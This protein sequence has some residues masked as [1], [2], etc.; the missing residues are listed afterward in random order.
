MP[1]EYPVIGLL[2]PDKLLSIALFADLS[3]SSRVIDFGCGFGESLMHLANQFHITGMGI[4]ILANH[5]D[6]ANAALE[7]HSEDIEFVQAD[8][9][10]YPFVPE[11]FDMAICI[12]ATNMFGTP[13]IMFRNAI[14]FMRRAIKKTGHLLIAEPCYN[15][16]IVPEQLIKYEGPLATESKLLEFARDEGYEVV[17]IVHSDKTDWDRYISTNSHDSVTWLQDNKNHPEWN[18]VLS[19]HREFQ[20]MYVRYRL[21]FQESVALL[22]TAI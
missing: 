4:D 8:V 6:R 10:K 22:M 2:S 17:C 11:S 9:L 13:D 19:S 3:S 12:N 14:K 5:V 16:D 18:Q 20:D 21:K 15:T 7:G 1:R